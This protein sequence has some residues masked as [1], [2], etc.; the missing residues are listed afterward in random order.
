MDRLESLGC[1]AKG[2]VRKGA[3]RDTLPAKGIASSSVRCGGCGH[4]KG[5]VLA[6]K[7]AGQ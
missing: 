6:A 7:Y 4:T 5:S 3:G 2:T 1:D